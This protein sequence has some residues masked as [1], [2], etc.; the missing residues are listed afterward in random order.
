MRALLRRRKV[1]GLGD[2]ARREIEAAAKSV[3]EG[4]EEDGG[5]ADSIEGRFLLRD[6]LFGMA[7]M[8]GSGGVEFGIFGLRFRPEPC[9]ALG[10][11]RSGVS[12]RNS[13]VPQRLITE[14]LLGVVG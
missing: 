6:F 10:P 7:G 9:L 14:V 11:W 4:W 3:G 13:T 2:G 12:S 8:V 5:A 1:R